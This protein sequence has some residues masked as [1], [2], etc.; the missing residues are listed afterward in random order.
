MKL[1]NYF[2]KNISTNISLPNI[3]DRLVNQSL[4]FLA[5]FGLPGIVGSIFRSVISG[6]QPVMTAQ[7]VLY[8]L[9]VGVTIFHNRVSFYVRTFAL[10]GS[11]FLLSVVG[12]WSF[13]LAGTALLSFGIVCLLTAVLLGTRPAIISLLVCL[14]MLVFTGYG[15]VNEVIVYSFDANKYIA[16]PSGWI[17]AIL[18]LLVLTGFI[19]IGVGETQAQLQTALIESETHYKTLFENANDAIYISDLQGKMLEVNKKGCLQIGYHKEELLKMEV[20]DFV[21]ENTDVTGQRTAKL[22]E[23]GQLYSDTQHIHKNGQVIPIELSATIIEYLGQPA[24]LGIARDITERVQSEQALKESETTLNE[25]FQSIPIG[26]AILNDRVIIDVNEAFCQMLEFP[27]ES[28]EGQNARILYP[29]DEEYEHVGRVKFPKLIEHGSVVIETKFQ[30]KGGNIIDVLLRSTLIDQQDMSSGVISTVVDITEQKL[31]AA[32]LKESE[33]RYRTL[34]EMSPDGI[35]LHRDNKLIFVNEAMMKLLG[36]NSIE[37]LIGKPIDSIVHPDT[38]ERTL[39][40]AKRMM[41]GESGIYPAEDVYLRLDGTAVP[42]EVT[43]SKLIFQGE[44]VIQVVARDISQRKEFEKELQ[45]HQEILE[46]RI[47]S[48]TGELEERIGEV[49]LLNNGML[50]LLADLQL[51]NENVTRIARQ[52]EETNAELEA[53]AYSVSHDLRAP[54]RHITGFVT[55]LQ[56]REEE[57]LDEKSFHYLQVI[58]QSTRRMGQLID[59]LLAFSRTSRQ[60]L[61]RKTVNM[62]RLVEAAKVELTQ[63]MDAREINWDVAQLPST[64]ADPGLLRQVWGNLLEN[65]I[66]YTAPMKIAHIE[67]GTVQ[68]EDPEE[69]IYF[70]RDNG[71]GFDNRYVDKL[72]GVFQRLH[73][74]EEFEGTG[75]G[76][77]TVRRI[78]HKHNGRVWAEGEE[79]KGATFFI[80]MPKGNI[81]AK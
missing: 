16:S 35:A 11:I 3:R 27:R 43:V 10:I 72:F 51:T 67:I 17:F 50:N 70:I 66:K 5:V 77:A 61:K 33:E 31:L 60:D 81:Y 36:A 76:L 13:G 59:D 41:A 74:K 20:K 7:L 15:A 53:F 28:F 1:T 2:S 9:I 80:A 32:G 69:I 19:I 65:A 4:L 58:K 8:L 12:L 14:L 75:I 57:R 79:G 62:N 49:E 30:K 34:V 26:A 37:S 52:L 45:T 73:R 42:V 78:I 68:A 46:A 22:L 40:R 21:A 64:Y 24:I 39:E 63:N 56:N 47:A 18:G 71:V 6:W 23:K 48:R 25:I 55:M 29:D 44:T 54:L 38:W